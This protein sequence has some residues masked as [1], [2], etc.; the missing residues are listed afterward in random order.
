MASAADSIAADDE[1]AGD[2]VDAVVA[3]VFD[4]IAFDQRMVSG[5][6]DSV[7]KI[8]Q[9]IVQER[10]A[11]SR[12]REPRFEGL[13]DQSSGLHP[14]V[15]SSVENELSTMTILSLGPS[16]LWLSMLTSGRFA[17]PDFAA[18]NLTPRNNQ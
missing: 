14:R 18:W 12:T 5:D 6:C 2:D 17:L 13:V 11:A 4:Q 3:K 16:Q 9:M 15:S 10:H 8:V 7:A 1:V